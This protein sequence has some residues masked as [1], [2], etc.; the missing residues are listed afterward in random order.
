MSFTAIGVLG[1]RSGDPE[2]GRQ[3]SLL[4]GVLLWSL[5]GKPFNSGGLVPGE[6]LALSRPSY[7][8]TSCLFIAKDPA[9]RALA[10]HGEV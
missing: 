7:V 9:S 2:M 8:T 3:A 5:S 4:I 10:G 6:S 1:C